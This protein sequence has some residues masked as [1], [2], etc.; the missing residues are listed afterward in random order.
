[1]LGF[2]KARAALMDNHAKDTAEADE[3]R[4]F[5]QILVKN[6]LGTREEMAAYAHKY[7]LEHAIGPVAEVVTTSRNMFKLIATQEGSTAAYTAKYIFDFD[8]FVSNEDLFDREG[9][10]VGIDI[11]IHTGKDRLEK[12]QRALA[13]KEIVLRNCTAIG[14]GLADIPVLMEAKV[15]LASPDATKEVLAIPGIIGL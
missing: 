4:Q 13:R 6:G 7:M 8:D 1:M 11:T 15:K 3:I 10:L 12:V 9:K 2:L 14:D 5:Y